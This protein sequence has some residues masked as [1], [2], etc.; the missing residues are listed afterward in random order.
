M[1]LTLAAFSSGWMLRAS[2]AVEAMVEADHK[3][4]IVYKKLMAGIL[5]ATQKGKLK[6][7]QRAW[8]AWIVAEDAFRTALDDNSKAGLF[9][10]IE[11]LEARAA[12][13]ESL[14]QNR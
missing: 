10:R 5:S 4:N 11:L 12:Q 14:L 9:V 6:A 2:V 13:L 1:I 3:L 7:A 8:L